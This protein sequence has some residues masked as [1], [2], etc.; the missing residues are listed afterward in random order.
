MYRIYKSLH[1]PTKPGVTMLEK[2]KPKGTGSSTRATYL[3]TL[4]KTLVAT[5]RN[6]TTPP[7][8]QTEQLVVISDMLQPFPPAQASLPGIGF[9]TIGTAAPWRGIRNQP[10]VLHT[11]HVI[12]KALSLCVVCKTCTP[13][14]GILM[15]NTLAR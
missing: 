9:G 11:T 5:S 2:M 8:Y 3:S 13:Y 15:K 12:S 14:C 6:N 1:L 10:S 7:K 4:I